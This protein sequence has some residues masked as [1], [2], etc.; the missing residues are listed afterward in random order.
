LVFANAETPAQ[1]T[2]RAKKLPLLF[3]VCKF[4][5]GRIN[6]QTT[7]EKHEGN[8]KQEHQNG[9]ETCKGFV[10][11]WLSVQTKF[12]IRFWQRLGNR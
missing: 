10:G 4:V 9:G 1:K 7:D 5:Y 8:K 11:K 2:K 12:E 3:A 6:P